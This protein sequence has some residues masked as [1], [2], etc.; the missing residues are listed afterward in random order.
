MLPPVIE[1]LRHHLGMYL[2]SETFDCVVSFLSGYDEAQSGGFLIGFREWLVV[3]ADGGNNLAWPSLVLVVLGVPEERGESE[4]LIE[5]LFNLLEE[6]IAVRQSHNGLR[7]I[8]A[9]YEDWLRRQD[10]Y[11]AEYG[12]GLSTENRSK[13]ATRQRSV[14]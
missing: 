11:T 1:S 10:W 4:K 2:R 9:R 6:F 12:V 13:T 3:R 14:E 8:F 5:G 7:Q